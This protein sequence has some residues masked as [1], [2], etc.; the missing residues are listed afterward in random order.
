[1]TREVRLSDMT[2]REKDTALLVLSGYSRKLKALLEELAERN[3][4]VRHRLDDLLKE[5]EPR[6]GFLERTYSRA[7]LVPSELA[8]EATRNNRIW[9]ELSQ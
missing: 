8:R 1:M 2:E 3:G 7:I 5:Y 9:A 6:L 4:Y